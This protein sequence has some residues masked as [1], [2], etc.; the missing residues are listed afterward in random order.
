M[1]TYY[2]DKNKSLIHI[3][4]LMGV[5][6]LVFVSL[7][8]YSKLIFLL[9]LQPATFVEHPWTILTSLFVHSGLWHI[10]FSM[11]LLYFFGSLLNKL[12]NIS[13][14]L[15]IYFIGGIVGNILF[16][17]LASP[18]VTFIGS[19]GAVFALAGAIILLAPKSRHIIRIPIWIVITILWVVFILLPGFGRIYILVGFV[20]GLIIGC[21]LRKQVHNL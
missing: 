11:L 4:I 3:W 5:N 6:F 14:F 19:G 7:L 16:L 17:F 9:G 18:L 21:I 13:K 15:T 12:V 2:Q 1:T 20:S 10:A 8:A